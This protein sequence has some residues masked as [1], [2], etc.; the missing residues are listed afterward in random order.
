MVYDIILRMKKYSRET[1]NIGVFLDIPGLARSRAISGLYRFARHRPDWRIF[2]FS[3]QRE[4]N[5]LRKIVASFRPD[6]IF[7]G[8]SDA[9]RAYGGEIPYV[10]LENIEPSLPL[11]MGATLNVDNILLGCMAAEKLHSL[12]YR[13]FGYLGI[14]FSPETSS[15]DMLARYSRIRCGAF[16][17]RIRDFGFQISSHMPKFGSPYDEPAIIAWLKSL[18]KPCGILAF[19]DEDAQYIISICHASRISIPRQ[20]GIISIDNEEYICDNVVPPLTSI[21]PDFEGAG[22]RAGA[23]LDEFLAGDRSH[24]GAKELYGAVIHNR[25]SAQSISSAANRAAHALEMIRADPANAPSPA[26]IA[27]RMNLSLRSLELA[28][29]QIQGHSITTEILSQRLLLARRL[30]KASRLSIGEIASKCGFSGHASF[31]A[32]FRRRFGETPRDWR[33]S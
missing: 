28:F 3:V 30:L 16:E 7:T 2:Q 10:M 23:I 19:S 27:R 29:K 33:N 32:S 26:T 5:A 6:A 31:L 21:E 9:I 12:G 14:V 22:Y 1:T 20:I 8:H 15:G 13:N 17:R 25:M 18:K 4:G 24:A 11:G